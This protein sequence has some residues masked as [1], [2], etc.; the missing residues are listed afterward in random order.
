MEAVGY[1]DKRVTYVNDD[2]DF[3]YDRHGDLLKEELKKLM[4]EL[5][6]WSSHYKTQHKR[7]WRGH[8]R[9]ELGLPYESQMG[10]ER[11]DKHDLHEIWLEVRSDD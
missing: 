1:P 9:D 2:G 5:D 7:A 11:F 6:M 8:I 10:W 3:T 4:K